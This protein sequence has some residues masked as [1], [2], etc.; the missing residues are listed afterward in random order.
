MATNTGLDPQSIAQEIVSSAE[1]SN[2]AVTAKD[3]P[4][5]PSL[6]LPAG[7]TTQTTF[8][9]N[10]FDPRFPTGFVTIVT[11]K[12]DNPVGYLKGGKVVPLL[13]PGY[14]LAEVE[15]QNSAKAAARNK[16][17]YAQ[18]ALQG[19]FNY[20]QSL[21]ETA[22]T[23]Y[24][25]MVTNAQIV[26]RGEATPQ[27]KSELESIARE[28][29]STMAAIKAAYEKSGAVSGSIN[30]DP[31]TGNL[32]VGTTYTNPT[33]NEPITVTSKGNVATPGQPGVVGGTKEFPALGSTQA[34]TTAGTAGQ[35]PLANGGK[36]GTNAPTVGQSAGTTATTT[37][38]PGATTTGTTSTSTTSSGN[39]YVTKNGVLSYNDN[40]FTGEYQ[41][42]YYS[43]GKLETADQIKT[44]F[45]A[46]YGEQAKFIASVP[47]LGGTGGLL[48]QA[49]A[50]NWSSTLWATKFAA[51]NWAQAHP[52]DIG[53]AEIKRIST[54]TQY[55]TEYNAA[56][57]RASTL[58]AQLGINLTP[59]Q[60]G[61]QI[62]GDAMSQ[63]KNVDQNAIANGQD[64]VNWILQNPTATDAQVQQRMAKYGT[65]DTT[66]GPG[67]SI[68]ATAQS[69]AQTAQQYGTSGLYTQDLLNKY[70][71]NIAQG[72]AGYDSNTFTEQQKQ[73][74]I[75]MYKP[76]A[77]QIK[78]GATVAS[79]ADPYVSTVASL[80][81]V[82]P[83]DVTLG[84]NNGLGKLVADAM[85]GDG[86][87]AVDPLSFANTVRAQ[88]QWL[89]TENAQK[90]LLGNANAIIQKMG[91]G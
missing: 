49:I 25:Q 44:D 12:N 10:S 50:G 3:N 15:R 90:T 30:L 40:P 43:N 16:A 85:K 79:L 54:P 48:D 64:I 7:Q 22:Q 88:P 8:N 37:T 89:N 75:N 60:L 33:T 17:S 53:L 9:V 74:A 67:G 31:K 63:V 6:N 55:N 32:A 59:D 78:A 58:A 27:Q 91:L 52:G 84:A 61:E 81:E 34:A 18:S 57:N 77:D 35:S 1:T 86:Q 47:E 83:S 87:T 42:K 56:Q 5:S 46:K 73:N 13:E 14:S 4:T 66:T 19:S 20:A 28:Y 76:F 41:G 45:L 23:E 62:T 68:A 38:T 70:A 39:N 69:L 24:Q 2:T 21:Q 51:T 36:P 11:D 26:S 82:N 65:I 72:Q 71:L 29:A 80:L